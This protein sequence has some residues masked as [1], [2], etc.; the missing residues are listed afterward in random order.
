MWTTELWGVLIGGALAIV[1]GLGGQLLTHYLNRRRES[2]TLLRERGERMVEALYQHKTWL[3][4]KRIAVIFRQ[5]EHDKPSPLEEAKMLQELYFP[6]FSKL[7]VPIMEADLNMTQFI[8][9]Q[10][11]S[12]M[13]DMNVW[14]ASVNNT[15]YNNYY[16][17]YIADLA[18]LVIAVRKKLEEH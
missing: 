12:Q 15:P 3:D 2:R 6:S 14:L 7:I 8:G 17:Q 4:D 16:K 10:R 5:L 9:Q 11:I 18:V 1:G 13:K